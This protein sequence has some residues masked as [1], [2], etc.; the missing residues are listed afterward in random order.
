MG[1]NDKWSVENFFNDAGVF[2]AILLSTAT[3]W[4]YFGPLGL[5]EI[6]GIA[7]VGKFL[8]DVVLGTSRISVGRNVLAPICL[9]ILALGAGWALN[10]IFEYSDTVQL[11]DFSA[12]VYAAGLGFVAC[13]LAD[14]RKRTFNL[15]LLAVSIP[16]ILQL[17]FLFVVDYG[18][19]ELPFQVR[20]EDS[21]RV[22]GWADNPNQLGFVLAT[23]PFIAIFMYRTAPIYCIILLAASALL[24]FGVVTHAVLFGWV[25]GLAAMLVLYGAATWRYMVSS[26]L[27]TWALSLGVTMVFVTSLVWLPT[28]VAS[29]LNKND[30]DDADGRFPLWI[31]AYEGWLS[32]PI[33]GFGPGAHSGAEKPFEATEAHNIILDVMLQSG[34]VGLVAGAVLITSIVLCILKR[35][36][37][38]ML[39]LVVSV[40][41]T[42]VGGNMLRHPI[43]WVSLFIALVRH[44]QTTLGVDTN[45]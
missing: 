12:I 25:S 7:V 4:R 3:Q 1:F 14:A 43:F 18:G 29:S 23:T 33:F 11:R 16:V 20:A 28:L 21:F 22:I 26:S 8:V 41:V 44:A 40:L 39:G 2:T 17:V 13:N 15:L 6:A 34:V 38:A 37:Y 31:N 27:R 19:V 32:S 5:G 36:Q 24:E 42:G 30:R 10:Y 45:A 35:R 9:F